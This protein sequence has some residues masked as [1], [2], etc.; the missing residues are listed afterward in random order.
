MTL[1]LSITR[2]SGERSRRKRKAKWHTKIKQ[3]Y[4]SDSLPR[5][6]NKSPLDFLQQQRKAFNFRARVICILS[7]CPF[8]ESSSQKQQQRQ[9]KDKLLFCCIYISNVGNSMKILVK[10]LSKSPL[11]GTQRQQG[12][13]LEDMIPLKEQRRNMLNSTRDSGGWEWG[14]GEY[15]LRCSRSKQEAMQQKA[16]SSSVQIPLPDSCGIVDITV[17]SLSLIFFIYEMGINTMLHSQGCGGN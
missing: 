3:N 5:K 10:K 14:N 12:Q 16:F 2:F 6:K 4:E 7:Q 1:W 8:T 15:S 13:M 9:M 11:Q 17:I